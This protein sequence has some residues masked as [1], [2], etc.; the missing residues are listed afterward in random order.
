MDIIKRMTSEGVE[1]GTEEYEAKPAVASRDK[2]PS[3]NF[4]QLSFYA[5][6]LLVFLAPIFFLP[7]FNLSL[8]VNKGALLTVLGTSAFFFWLIQRLKD[9]KFVFPKS[10]VLGGL[11]LVSLAF[12]LASALSPVPSQS[13]AGLG[14][15]VGTFSFILLLSLVAFLSSM[16]FQVKKMADAFYA[17]F[18][19]SILVL[20]AYQALRF[21]WLSSGLPGAEFFL[22]LPPNLAGKWTDLATLFG[23][24]AI[25]SL[26]KLE[27]SEEADGKKN[28]LHAVWGISI[29]SL[30]ATNFSLLWIVVGLFALIVLVYGM[31]FGVSEEGGVKQRKVPAASFATVIIALFFILSGNLV[32]APLFS[33]FGI[34]L[35][36][37]APSW[38]DTGSIIKNTL[39]EHPLAGV[40]PNRFGIEWQLLK[41]AD[42]NVTTMWAVDFNA[43]A[44]LVP[45]FV[46]TTGVAG[47][48]A[49]T[50][51]FLAFL[52]AGVTSVFMQKSV[53]PHHSLRV[54]SFLGS[55][56]VWVIAVLYVP[57][58]AVLIFAFLLTG[59][60]VGSLA[61]GKYVA[62][63]R[64]SFLED[65]RV[66]FVSMLLLI[67]LIMSSLAGGYV[68]FQKFI[69]IVHYQQGRVL[70]SSGDF[71]GAEQKI[72]QAIR[73]NQHDEYLRFLAEVNV[74][75]LSG[76]VQNADAKNE[77]AR[78]NIQAVAQIAVENALRATTFDGANY[79][80]WFT[81]G[82][83]YQALM[84][85]GEKDKL[86]ESAKSAYEKARE[87]APT[88]PSLLLALARLEIAHE[89]VK[90]AKEYIG[91]ALTMKGNYTEA[92]FLLSQIQAS[93]GNLKDAIS[94]AEIASFI[95]PNDS[96]V[97]LQLG[98]LKYENKD[99]RGSVTAF[100]RVL[101]LNPNYANAKYF[102]GLAYQKV[103]EKNKALDIFYELEKNNPDNEEVKRVLRTL[104]GSGTLPESDDEPL[105]EGKQLP[106]KEDN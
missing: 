14:F 7:T 25:L 75:E 106:I 29:F 9:A 61:E 36:T 64:L 93:E 46:I 4:D 98:L 84:P 35:E 79:L 72:V 105:E 85:I 18:F 20:F 55:A 24:S 69:S 80:N 32:T 3:F 71:L 42:V 101:A 65:P 41:P 17:T 70:A 78:A 83:V 76:L 49:F 87:L 54:L 94:S 39:S 51:L 34:P 90:K 74:A 53:R 58:I 60:F 97:F 30:I 43:T 27:L 21:V 31:S 22:S 95:S 57:N 102:L 103:G 1:G 40:G 92:V 73:L 89:D 96:G 81:L 16:F 100:E 38:S 37:I 77:A 45:T 67:L 23:L 47:L 104:E 13:F 8:D 66:G 56:Y 52:Y 99:Y 11:V 48:L 82:G 59:V 88:N 68:M 5:I 12:L 19:I 2:K 15:E 6:L 10:A 86:Y 44:G 63:Y 33:F 62:N 50:L 28:F 26:V 91:N